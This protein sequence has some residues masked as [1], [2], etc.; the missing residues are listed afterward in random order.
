MAERML[1]KAKLG[2]FTVDFLTEKPIESGLSVGEYPSRSGVFDEKDINPQDI[3]LWLLGNKEILAKEPDKLKVGGWLDGGKVWL[4][5]V[6]I[7]DPSEREK[8]IQSGRDHNQICIADL[9]AIKRGDWDHAFIDTKGTGASKAA[10]GGSKSGTYFM[11]DANAT[12]QQIM[13]AIKKHAK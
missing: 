9:D 5:I 2:G 1:E 7:Y 6:R 10:S 3:Q 4:D 11:L 8:A 12:A 13:D